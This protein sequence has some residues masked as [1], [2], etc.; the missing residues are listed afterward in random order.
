MKN[1]RN[2]MELVQQIGGAIGADATKVLKIYETEEHLKNIDWQLASWE[3]RLSNRCP[4][5]WADE[6][7]VLKKPL[8]LYQK[9]IEKK[10]LEVELVP[11]EDEKGFIHFKGY[12]RTNEICKECKTKKFPNKNIN[13]KLV[14][15]R[16][17]D[18]KRIG[19]VGTAYFVWDIN[20]KLPYV[21]LKEGKTTEKIQ[22]QVKDFILDYE[23]S[24]FN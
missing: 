13:G 8:Y 24:I 15:Y 18:N 14:K 17:E 9:L 6:E 2:E 1:F 22:E 5:C 4:I 10:V 23:D 20:S 21:K 19:Y 11:E 12:I 16:L 7:V 3:I